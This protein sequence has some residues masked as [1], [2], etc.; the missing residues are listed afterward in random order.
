MRKNGK[1]QGFFPTYSKN[2]Q[3]DNAEELKAPHE[4]GRC[5]NHQPQVHDDYQDKIPTMA[6]FMLPLGELFRISIQRPGKAILD[7]TKTIGCMGKPHWIARS[8]L[9]KDFPARGLTSVSV[10]HRPVYFHRL[11]PQIFFFPPFSILYSL[12]IEALQWFR[13]KA[14]GPPNPAESD[15]KVFRYR[16]SSTYGQVSF[17]TGPFSADFQINPRG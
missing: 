11:G 17:E 3:A 7:E 15:H 16:L 2:G 14:A 6:F 8:F 10:Q 1:A 5:G 9:L 13:Q 4:S 12:L